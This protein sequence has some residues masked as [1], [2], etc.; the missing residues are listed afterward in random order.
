MVTIIADNYFGYCKKE[1]KTQIS[2]AANLFGLCEE[3]HAGGAHRLPQPTS[4]AR[5]STPAAPCSLTE[6]SLRGGDDAARRPRR[7]QARRLR[8]STATIPT[9]STSRRTPSSTCARDAFAGRGRT[10]ARQLTLRAGETYVLPS[11]TRCAWRS[12]SPARRGGWSAR[13]ATAR[14]ATSPA[15]SPAAASPR[16]PSPSPT[17]CSTARSSSA[18]TTATWTPWPRS[19]RRDFSNIYRTPQDA[20]RARRPIL[21]P[22]RSLGSVIKLLTPSTEYTDEYNAWLRDLPQTIR[23]LVFIVKR[24]YRPEWGENWREHFTV[25]RIN[26]YLGHELKYRQPEAGQQLPARR[27]RS[28]TAPGASTSCARISI[29]PTRCRWKTTSPPRSWCRARALTDLDTK[30]RNTAASSWSRTARYRLFQRPDDAIHRGYD[31]QAEA[32]IASAGQ[33]PLQLRAAHLRAGASHRRAR[34]R[35]RPVHRADEATC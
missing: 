24:Y 4:W 32:D 8:A 26:G 23:Q 9:S 10:G 31:K 11:A 19:S 12:S 16:S 14:F 28:R 18:T 29:P 27:L 21:S 22:E 1:V 30:Y 6:T 15:P 5:N 34:R 20:A 13:G 3:E 2:Y 35:V 17:C 33:L 25:D 7:A